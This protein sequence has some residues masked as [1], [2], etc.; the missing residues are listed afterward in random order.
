MAG[1]TAPRTL[2]PSTS[3]NERGFWES[4]PV[5]ALNDELFAELGTSWHALDTVPFGDLGPE[6]LR[7]VTLRAKAVLESEFD[8]GSRPLIK[9]PRLSRLLP[10]WKP[11]FDGLGS[12]TVYAITVR[13]PL[14]VA[15]SLTQRNEFDSDLS[16][17]LWTRYYL[18]AEYHTRGLP[19]VW[20]TYDALIADWRRTLG[21]VG[22]R[23]G[24]IQ[25]DSAS[26]ERIDGFISAQLRHHR[27]ADE[28]ASIELERMAAVQQTYSILLNSAAKGDIDEADL[29]TLDAL[30]GRFDD[31]GGTLSRVIE[32]ARLDRKRLANSRAQGEA[33]AAELRQA[34]TALAD[35]DAVRSAL[36]MQAAAQLRLEERIDAAVGSLTEAIQERSILEQKLSDALASAADERAGRGE[37]EKKLA[38]TASERE[39][40]RAELDTARAAAARNAEDARRA[41]GDLRSS[42]EVIQAELKDVKRKYRS[43]QHQLARDREKLRRTQEQLADVE[44]TL[45]E[46]RHSRVW[47]TYT[48]LQAGVRRSTG[49]LH[50]VVGGKDRKRRAEVVGILRRSALFDRDWYLSRYPD[51]AAAGIDPVLHYLESG[52]REGRD[53]SP[54]FSTA[55]YLRANGDI[56]RAGVNPLLHYL[57]YGYSEGRHIAELPRPLVAGSSAPGEEMAPA[58]P[59]AS[60]P[61]PVQP[62]IRW[63]RAARMKGSPHDLVEIRGKSVGFARSAQQRSTVEAAFERLSAL[64][65]CSSAAS[66]LS[67]DRAETADT[68]S[69]L[70]D[71]WH[72][73]ERRLRSRWRADEGAKVIR[74][75]QHDIARKNPLT[76]TGEGLIASDTDF[77]DVGLTNPYFPTLFVICEPDGTI[78]AVRLLAFPSLCRGGLHY[79]ELVALKRC[80]SNPQNASIDVLGT[81]D[82]LAELLS[83]A[84]HEK[85][86][87]FIDK[88]LVDLAGADGSEPLF[89]NDFQAWLS[90]VFGAGIEPLAGGPTK[91]SDTYLQAAIIKPA[92]LRKGGR[93]I[94]LP[95]DTIPSISLLAMPAAAADAKD[96]EPVLPLVIANDD[97]AQPATLLS[98]PSTDEQPA[99]ERACGYPPVWPRLRPG[100][101]APEKG[102][103]VAAIRHHRRPL[104]NDSELLVPVAP[105][106]LNVA[107]NDR[108][109]T[110]L[111]FPED[112]AE[113]ALAQSME[114]LTVQASSKP[115]FVALVGEVPA[116][117]ASL[118]NDLFS[119]RV[120]FWPDLTTALGGI[121]TPL[122]GYL[123]AH[124]IL[125]DPRTCRVLSALLLDP[126]IVSASCVL[127]ST[128]KRGKGWQISVADAGTF[129]GMKNGVEPDP[130]QCAEAQLFWRTNYPTLR[131]P[132]DLWIARSSIARRWLQRAGPMRPEEGVQVCT[133][134]VTASYVA[135]RS[136]MP[137]HLRPPA[138]A[139]SQALRSDV[140]VG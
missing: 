37:L 4:E 138:S 10:L 60:F 1:F 129:A 80:A 57:E 81:A 127:V 75:Y 112:W 104:P 55:S 25:L 62:P 109:I 49:V 34:R 111:I 31:I 83:R 118:A 107:E 77:V 119:N 13:S 115:L 35:L 29:A 26:E 106:V 32:N 58:A 3:V 69:P 21:V 105:P 51:V 73:N 88:L 18:D 124:V 24:E 116:N 108:P 89:Q 19:R 67:V 46:L 11:A 135:D 5:K 66:L 64:S 12:K 33:A 28:Q 136:D 59:C 56:A 63:R 39:A 95:A 20:I 110:W 52:W 125:H 17:L 122:V 7:S 65:G 101:T 2:L 14:E 137:A 134:L 85:P 140:L 36:E 113:A 87:A 131:P 8:T 16:Y 78:T 128:E 130:R 79:P 44:R 102:P 103:A 74:A 38:A 30:R 42:H 82:G 133:S 50:R 6:R 72:V 117:I 41:M 139:E 97:P 70:I 98:V 22:N 114:G 27:A 96:G 45:T 43:T 9:D 121:Q 15:R 123:G 100:N 92:A 61:L 54:G 86:G 76:L 84:L 71:I 120:S 91:A 93:T 23:F 94:V 47:R 126:A 40:V 90:K 68:V 99:S 53:P 48:A 132:R